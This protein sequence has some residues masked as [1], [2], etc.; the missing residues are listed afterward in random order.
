MSFAYCSIC[1]K[2]F[3][4]MIVAAFHRCDEK[5]LKHIEQG[6]KAVPEVDERDMRTYGGRLQDG[7]KMVTGEDY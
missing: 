5:K 2:T 7:T 1:G 4:S 6:Y 3:S